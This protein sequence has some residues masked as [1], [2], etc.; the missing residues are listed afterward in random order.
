MALAITA[1]N[2]LASAN[3][4]K[5]AG[6][7]GAAITAGQ[8]LY[9]D[10]TDSSKLK[11]A[12]ADASLATANVVGIALNN[13]AAGQPV[14]YVTEDSDF[15]TGAA[16]MDIGAAYALGPGAGTIELVADIATPSVTTLLFIAKSATKAV[17]KIVSGG[18]AIPA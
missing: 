15:Q 4:L 12:D 7:A 1:A 5:A 14:N 6:T 18:V 16:G 8:P 10:A 11:P 3:A 17:M 9:K 2:V 13:A